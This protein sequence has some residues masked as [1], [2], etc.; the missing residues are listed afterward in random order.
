LTGND[1][2]HHLLS[3]PDYDSHHAPSRTLSRSALV[4]SQIPHALYRICTRLAS[5]GR[6]SKVF[7]R[8]TISIVLLTTLLAGIITPTG[9]CAL[10]CARHSPAG[11]RHHCGEDSEQMSGMPHNHSA[12]HHSG[13]GDI[14]LVVV[15]AQSCGTDCAV[16]ERLNGSRKVVHQVAVVQTGALV[17]EATFKF[18]TPHLESAWSLDNGPPSFPF[19]HTASFSILR[20]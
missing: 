9:V 8:I 17:L 2:G 14:R 11:T 18:L 7:S 16:A 3:Y 19:A 12:I 5:C 13:I 10:M 4:S 20:I 15:A 1:T 6:V